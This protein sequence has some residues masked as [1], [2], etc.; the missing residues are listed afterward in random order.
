MWWVKGTS[1]ITNQ[2]LYIP[3]QLIYFPY[4]FEEDELTLQVPITTGAAV[5]SGLEMA[6]INGFCEIAERDHFLVYYLN[7]LNPTKINLTKVENKDIDILVRKLERYNLEL[8]TFDITLDLPCICVMAI[9]ID[10]TGFGP[11]ISVG[12]KCGIDSL[13]TLVGAIEESFQTRGWI[14]DCMFDYKN[15]KTSDLY[16]DYELYKRGL[17][18]SDLNMIA[19]LSFFLKPKK[20][21]TVA[22][23]L[24]KY[25][26]ITELSFKGRVDILASKQLSILYKEVTTPDIE[27]QGLNV[28]RVVMPELQSLYLTEKDKFINK[29]RV[30][31]LPY[32]LGLIKKRNTLDN[33]NKIPHPFL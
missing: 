6:I 12:L 30:L 4:E 19:K 20:E 22:D 25:L 29:S 16:D 9:I 21:I 14:R 26:K 8:Q 23:F 3:A 5:G 2:E 24:K 32:N 11:S 10:R 13:S 1:L 17:Y 33:L 28:V 27:K 18:W 31:D 7:K 15:I